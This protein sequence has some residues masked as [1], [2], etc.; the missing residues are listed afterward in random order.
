MPKTCKSNAMAL[1]GLGVAN[2]GVIRKQR[3]LKIG[4]YR[5]NPEQY[6]MWPFRGISGRLN[7]F[8]LQERLTAYQVVGGVTAY[9][10]DD[11]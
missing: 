2:G 7:G 8:S 11:G 1:R 4:I 10:A 5:G 9:Q 3:A 6:R